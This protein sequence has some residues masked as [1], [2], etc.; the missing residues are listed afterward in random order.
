[1]RVFKSYNIKDVCLGLTGLPSLRMVQR[2]GRRYGHLTSV[3]LDDVKKI[4]L[5]QLLDDH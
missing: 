1:M 4:L 5:I 2:R 3:S